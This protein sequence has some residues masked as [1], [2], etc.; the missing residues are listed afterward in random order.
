MLR[1][2]LLLA[3]IVSATRAQE[4]EACGANA[5]V[6][7]GSYYLNNLVTATGGTQCVTEQWVTGATLGW[8]ATWTW[9]G[10]SATARAF[11]SCVLG[12]NYGFVV[13]DTG[14]PIQ[15]SEGRSVITSWTF[16][17]TAATTG[18]YNAA[19]VLYLHSTASPGATDSPSEE[20]QVWIDDT[21]TATPS[22][23][24]VQEVTIADVTWNLYSS[25]GDWSTFTFFKTQSATVTDDLD[26]KGFTDMLVS[27]SLVEDS[28]YLSSVQAGVQVYSGSGELDSTFYEVYIDTA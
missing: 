10:T 5:T 3:A 23:S 19:Y 28:R 25:S 22:G 6:T 27:L 20:V 24:L 21:S 15:L 2:V 26:L 8:S 11:P 18:T 7:V 9:S 4:T 17:V 14:L 12:W 16:D 13:D 1:F